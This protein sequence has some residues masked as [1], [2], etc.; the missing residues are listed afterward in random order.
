MLCSDDR[1]F[2]E[3]TC[4][5]SAGIIE[6]KK[7]EL[8][9][10]II[11]NFPRDNPDDVVHDVGNKW[12]EYKGWP[13]TDRMKVQRISS[14]RSHICSIDELKDDPLIRQQIRESLADRLIN[15][16]EGSANSQ[17]AACV[18]FHPYKRGK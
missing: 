2:T 15:E 11:C 17:A 7:R 6:A 12:R 16:T 5:A 3:K 13:L 9:Y 18:V 14:P 1:D 4:S 8:L 10:S